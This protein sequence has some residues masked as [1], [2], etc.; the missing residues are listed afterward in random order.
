M[1][2]IA[3]LAALCLALLAAPDAYAKGILI[4]PN[5]VDGAGGFWQWLTSFFA[6][7]DDSARIDP[8]G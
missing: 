1:K 7:G 3:V 6:H 2:Q 4:D 8:N 5:G